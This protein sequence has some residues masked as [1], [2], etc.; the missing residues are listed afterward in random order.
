MESINRWF[1]NDIRLGGID[2]EVEYYIVDYNNGVNFKRRKS[3]IRSNNI[4]KFRDLTMFNIKYFLSKEDALEAINKVLPIAIE[5]YSKISKRLDEL[6]E[7][8]GF[9]LENYYEGDTYGIYNEA[10]NI[11]FSMDGFN[12]SFDYN[13]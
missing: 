1:D 11:C 5:K 6:C 8:M 2:I 7:N 13:K 9:G 4:N 3:N 10:L 12:F